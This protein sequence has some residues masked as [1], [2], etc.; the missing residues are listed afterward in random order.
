MFLGP[1]ETAWLVQL[2]EMETMEGMGL[3]AIKTKGNR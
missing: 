2:C 3:L 1:V